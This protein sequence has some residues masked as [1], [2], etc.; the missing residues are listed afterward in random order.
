MGFYHN[1]GN[2]LEEQKITQFL[3]KYVES[4]KCSAQMSFDGLYSIKEIKELPSL[5]DSYFEG[6]CLGNSLL[7]IRSVNSRLSPL[8]QVADIFAGMFGFTLNKR[9]I[10]LPR[11][12]IV[13]SRLLTIYVR[14]I[15]ISA[16]MTDVVL[17]L[18]EKIIIQISGSFVN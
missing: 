1:E 9:V 3:R 17:Y 4:Q 14:L 6:F 2:R 13:S 15:K 8:I 11:A 10:L 18:L 5:T 12:A 7:E 16:V